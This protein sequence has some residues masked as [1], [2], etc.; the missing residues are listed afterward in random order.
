MN[1]K[2]L[3]TA[4]CFTLSGI[5]AAHAT[6]DAI[7][8]YDW[9]GGFVGTHS[10]YLFGSTK[11]EDNGIVV[12]SHAKTNGFISGVRAGYNWQDDPLVYG[13]EADFGLGFV[14]GHGNALPPE[15]PNK[16]KMNWNAH[17]RGRLGM[18]P[19]NSNLLL[20][21]GAGVAF[22]DF[23]FR[24]GD[25]GSTKSSIYIAPSIGVGAEYGFTSNLTG[26]VEVLYDV[27]DMGKGLIALD[28]YKAQFKNAAT[29]RVGLG[30]KF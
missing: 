28:D 1:I 13:L 18:A 20:F 8:S 24:D 25:T 16:Y 30:Y 29:I 26:R 7:G 23:E 15:P 27:F 17:L 11:V 2:T 9:S 21:V 3:F 22:A 5:V 12:E 10:G 4:A 14:K 6:D 19:D